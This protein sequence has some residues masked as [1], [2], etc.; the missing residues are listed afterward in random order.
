[1]AA[2]KSARLSSS[3]IACA[4]RSRRI[5]STGRRRGRPIAWRRSNSCRR[6]RTPPKILCIGLN[7]TTHLDEMGSKRPAYPTVFTR[8]AD[9]LVG[10]GGALVRPTSSTRFDYEG[11]LAVIVGRGG[12]HIARADA[13]AHVAGFSVFNDASVRDWQRHTGQF[14][15]G[16]N[17]PAT[18]GFGRAGYARRD[19]RPRRAAG[20]DPAQRPCSRTADSPTCCGSLPN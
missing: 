4:P 5:M 9:T 16:K 8:F 15:P 6:S 12:R 20:P 14:T 11:E 19:P 1:M 3:A 17:F 7:Y 10:D 13:M 2:S 18:G